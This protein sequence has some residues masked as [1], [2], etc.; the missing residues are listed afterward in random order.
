[1]QRASRKADFGREKPWLVTGRTV[2][3]CEA[4]LSEKMSMFRLSRAG[5]VARR[6]AAAS[7]M[8]CFRRAEAV[9]RLLATS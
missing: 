8:N 3:Q 1:M 7:A 5:K 9:A 4:P 2:S 6:V